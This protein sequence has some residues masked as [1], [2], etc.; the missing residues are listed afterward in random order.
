MITRQERHNLATGLA[1]LA[2]NIFGFLTFTLI[3]LILSLVL[4]FS[5]YDLRLHN[6]FRH[7]PLH[8][9]LFENFSRLFSQIDFWRYL[10]NTLFLMLSVPFGI[11][12]SLVTALLLNRQIGGSRR[13][14]RSMIIATAVLVGGVTLLI[15]V[16]AGATSL[17]IL[18][19][20]LACG[21][22]V[23][24][25]IGGISVYRTLFYIPSFTSGVAVY[26]LWT[27][28]YN[29]STGPLHVALRPML[30]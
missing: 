13:R 24:G 16:G 23:S 18:F 11:A 12:G 15:V 4:A 3:P 20:G 25:A 9:T 2:P 17:T 22:L 5:N 26:L 14:V 27:K 30:T 29:P 7:L 21:V 10:G 6:R 1:F 8:F 28:L 19:S